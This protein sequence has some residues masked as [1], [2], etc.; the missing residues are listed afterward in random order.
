MP[1]PRFLHVAAVF[2]I[3]AIAGCASAERK[4]SDATAAAVAAHP[5]CP[6]VETGQNVYAQ[7][8]EAWAALRRFGAIGPDSTLVVADALPEVIDRGEM[9][10]ILM[11]A[12]P[13][14]LRDSGIGG[15]VVLLMLVDE[16][17]VV[18]DV[19]VRDSS[20][21]AQLDRA[22]AGAASRVR[23]LPAVHE[24]CRIPVWIAFPVSFAT[25]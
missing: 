17:G 16:T 22:A 15:T 23:F 8:D 19:R 20:G 11:S 2:T 3:A 10:R 24:D 6:G 14:N 12:Y 21:S 7:S 1:E 18:A 9:S 4:A 5:V 13:A 25:S